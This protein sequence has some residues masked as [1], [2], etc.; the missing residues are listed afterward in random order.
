MNSLTPA[1]DQASRLR[2]LVQAL[3]ARGTQEEGTT[4]S[5]SA[6]NPAF[7]DPP[8]TPSDETRTLAPPEPVPPSPPRTRHPVIAIAS[9]KGGVGKSVIA[10]NLAVV[11]AGEG[12][13]PALV[14]ADLGA[15]NCDILLGERPLRRLGTDLPRDLAPFAIRTR[16]GPL[17]IPGHVGMR[18]AGLPP[19]AFVD[20]LHTLDAYC[21]AVVL[22][23]PAGLD[24][25]TIETLAQADIA[26]VV[27]TPEPPALA[28]AYALVKAVTH[29]RAEGDCTPRQHLELVPNQVRDEAH[30]RVVHARLAQV[31]QR[32]LGR[33]VPLCGAVPRCDGVARSVGARTPV[34]V[35]EPST[36]SARAIL[37]VASRVSDTIASSTCATPADASGF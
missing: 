3:R 24:H 37:A 16:H 29:R 31:A 34:V 7:A 12:Y 8:D 35:H 32:F 33:R 22:D 9:G 11:L 15:A 6:T 17:L 19:A 14:D 23:L 30:A 21:D 26:L 1:P 13:S 36:A 28:D 20:R 2:S 10:T 5:R 18:R 25:L 4:P 27:T